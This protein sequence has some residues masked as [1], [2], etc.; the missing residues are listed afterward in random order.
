MIGRLIICALLSAYVTA[1]LASAVPLSRSDT[2][3]AAAINPVE[4]MAVLK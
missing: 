3:L 2:A 1:M 4:V